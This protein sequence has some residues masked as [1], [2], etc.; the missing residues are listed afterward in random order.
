MI[1]S[2]DR[3]DEVK[4]LAEHLGITETYAEQSPHQK[5][6]RVVHET[7]KRKTIFLG[8]GINDAPALL[9]ATVGISLGQNSDIT[10]EASGAI[11]L[12]GL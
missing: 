5:Y 9:A 4:R 12:E 6:T 1:L 2:G 3:V 11:I 7:K 8:D 10:S